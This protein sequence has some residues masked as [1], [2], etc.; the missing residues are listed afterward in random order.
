[1]LYLVMSNSYAGSIVRSARK[2]RGLSQ[3]ELA[4][5]TGTTQSAISRL[6]KGSSVPSFDR[7]VAL[8]ESMGLWL[9]ISLV[10][11]D[12]DDSAIERNLTLDYQQRR[13]N[14]VAATRFVEKARSVSAGSVD[15]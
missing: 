14:A 3:R 5:L 7:V 11:R 15:T 1:M 4:E 10:E 9:E 6:E 13:D 2:R 12:W 8:V